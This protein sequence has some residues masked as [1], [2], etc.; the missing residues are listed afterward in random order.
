MH[1]SWSK[2]R[3]WRRC[4]QMYHYKYNEKLAKRRPP[5]PLIRGRIIGECLDE[6][7]SG[8][9]IEGVLAHYE[10]EYGRL[11]REEKEEYGDMLPEISQLISGYRK[12]YK[13]D[14]LKF[15]S[16]KQGRKRIKYEF[17]LEV[18]LGDDITFIGYIDKLVEDH[19]GVFTLDHKSH[20]NIPDED[21]RFADLQ[22]VFY[23]WAAP[24]CG[25][26]KPVG[27]CW[28]YLRTSPP[29]KPEVLKTGWLTERKNLDTDYDTYLAAILELGQDPKDYAET[30]ERLQAQTNRWYQRVFLPSPPEAMVD[31]AI[32]D[33]VTT[34]NEI[35]ELGETNHTRNMGRECK[36]CS[37]FQ[38]CQAEYR[39]LDANFIRKSEFIVKE[40]SNG[41]NK[42]T[43]NG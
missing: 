17:P 18:D 20:R 24:Q 10:K 15:L 2:A 14:G 11:F 7:V 31:N 39:G 9:S 38:L 23:T 4:H 33:L 5:P 6:V 3:T 25:Y 36:Q 42:E 21:T 27:V 32:Y 1:I 22:L 12:Y 29:T 26:P 19:R 16:V 30:L 28:D 35:R 34:A 40:P 13:N 8:R 41:R 37:Y 43:E